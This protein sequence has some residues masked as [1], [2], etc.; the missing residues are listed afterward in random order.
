MRTRTAVVLLIA[1]A[2]VSLTF[3]Y[4]LRGFMAI[5]SCLDAGGRWNYERG[6]CERLIHEDE[7]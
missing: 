6:F 7:R 4:W 2:I 1:V 5:D 3:G